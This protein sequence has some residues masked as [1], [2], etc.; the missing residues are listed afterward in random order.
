MSKAT[1]R[2]HVVKE[3]LGDY[4]TPNEKQQIMRVRFVQ[5]TFTVLFRRWLCSMLTA[6]FA[7]IGSLL[8]KFKSV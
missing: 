3:V 2:K 1:K 4:I 7:Y 5:I 6:Y 8:V